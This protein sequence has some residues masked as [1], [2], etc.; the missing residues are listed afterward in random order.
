MKNPIRW[1]LLCLLTFSARAQVQLGQETVEGAT[2]DVGYT[3]N[4]A[5]FPAPVSPTALEYFLLVTQAPNTE[6]VPYSRA[7]TVLN[8]QQGQRFWAAERVRGTGSTPV[9]DADYLLC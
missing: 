2:T 4:T 6:Y 1:L 5:I 9:R 7:T 3:S 8:N